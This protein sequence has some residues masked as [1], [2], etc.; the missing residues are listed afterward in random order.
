MA[1]TWGT[2]QERF[3]RQHMPEPNSG[4]WLWIGATKG[5]YGAI[6]VRGR[7]GMRRAHRVSYELHVGPIGSGLFVCH[8]CDVPLC[9][10]PEHLFLGTRAD[11]M[12]DMVRKGRNRGPQPENS[13][14]AKL[15]AQQAATVF[16]ARADDVSASALSARFGVSENAIW[17]IWCGRTW[18][19]V[20]SHNGY[21]SGR[22]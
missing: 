16:K 18:K 4:C 12:L 7:K 21:E 20:T 19:A 17:N 3:D 11:N 9:V 22:Y 6:K 8:K 2:L 10:N 1:G 15:T 5:N 14:T 13:R